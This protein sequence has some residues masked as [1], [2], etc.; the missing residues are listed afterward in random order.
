[1]KLGGT[2]VKFGIR[3]Y[4]Q[5]VCRL[6]IRNCKKRG[7]IHVPV[8]LPLGRKHC[9]PLTRWLSTSHS[10]SEG[11]EKKISLVPGRNPNTIPHSYKESQRDALFLIFI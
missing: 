3:T 5:H 7:Q 2:D 11:T 9:Y 1:M 4:H 6:H 10:L 8:A